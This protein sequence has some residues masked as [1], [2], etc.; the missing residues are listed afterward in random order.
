[1]KNVYFVK[2]SV[3]LGALLV[4]PT[5]GWSQTEEGKT[6]P[7]IA[8]KMSA[9][10]LDESS[11]QVANGIEVLASDWP[12]LIIARFEVRSIFGTYQGSC[13]ASLVGPNVALMA[14]HC[15]DP[16]ESDPTGDALSPTLQVGDRIIGMRC[17]MHPSYRKRALMANSPRGAEDFALCVLEDGGN[18]PALFSKI[19]FEVVDAQTPLARAAQVLLTGYGCDHVKIVNGGLTFVKADGRL[20][21]GD[22]KVDSPPDTLPD[23]GAYATIRSEVDEPAL[24]PGDSGGPVMTGVTARAP[25]RSRRIRAVNSSLAASGN[26]LVSS[27]SVTGS[28]VFRDWALDWLRR[29]DRFQPQFCGMNLRAG[30]QRCRN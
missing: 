29:H 9:E 17:E 24:C 22:A 4:F 30:E 15:V 6:R 16:K 11:V 19:L 3:W 26:E 5:A 1:M 8:F 12:T 20:R 18:R 28:A 14:A 27:V 13:T 2:W 21:I 10:V 23:A 7:T 25:D